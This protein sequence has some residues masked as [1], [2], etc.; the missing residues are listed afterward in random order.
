MFYKIRNFYYEIKGIP[1]RLKRLLEYIPVIWK[2]EDWDSIYIYDL[3]KYKLSRTKKALANGILP[4]VNLENYLNDIS[5]CERL[6]DNITND[7][8]EEKYLQEHEAKWGKA[9]NISEKFPTL[10]WIEKIKLWYQVH[11]QKIPENYRVVE[12]LIKYEK[13]TPENS[14][15][16]K[17]E[18]IEAINKAQADE[19]ADKEKLFKIL[20]EHL[21]EWWD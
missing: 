12:Y 11:I 2:N 7:N 19:E 20:K 14:S 5:E 21:D 6:I 9:I 15:L 3:L 10:T 17:S 18:F 16:I 13:E 1:R 4:S 8:Y